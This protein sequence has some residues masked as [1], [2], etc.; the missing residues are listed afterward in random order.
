MLFS[1]SVPLEA[2]MRFCRLARHGLA[3]GLSLVDVFRQQALSGPI[4]MRSLIGRIAVQLERGESLED[5]LKAEGGRLPP[6]FISLVAVG[7]HTGHL[8]EAFGELEHYY[9]MQWRLRKQFL[10]DITWPMIEFFGA[11]GVITLLLLILGWIAQPGVQLDPFGIGVGP[12]AATTFLLTVFGTL[13]VIWGGYRLLARATRQR[14]VVDRFL[15]R[16]PV[17]GPCLEALALARFCLAG[18]LTFGAGL[19]VKPAL[20]RSLEATGNAAYPACY[21]R[22]AAVVRR[23]DDLATVLRAC[24]IFPGEFLEIVSNA[25]EAGRVPEVMEQQSRFY[26][27]EAS[28]RMKVLAKLAGFGVWALVAILII[29]AI[30]KIYVGAYLEQMNQ[31][32][33]IK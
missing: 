3:A 5:A 2:L 32:L 29:I 12:R 27:E 11:V 17:F 19:A 15:L 26:Q 20:R 7:E 16:L 8:P 30:F 18:R 25:E 10:A 9:E 33:N 4:P 23:G 31:I 13:A 24:Q 28:L 14:A 22:A 6:L 21:E 1:T